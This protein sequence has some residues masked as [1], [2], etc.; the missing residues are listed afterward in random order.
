M[1]PRLA[2]TFACLLAVL[3]SGAGAEG[4]GIRRGEAKAF[5]VLK[6]TKRLPAL[7]QG[8]T[9][10][11]LATVAWQPSIDRADDPE[12]TG[13][14]AKRQLLEASCGA[15]LVV[16]ARVDGSVPFRHPNNRWVLTLH[17]LVVSRVVRRRTPRIAR[18]ERLRYVHPSGELSVAGRI[19]RTT[20]D[21]FPPIVSDEDA[22]FF[23]VQIDATTYRSSEVVPPMAFRG[24]ML[25]ALGEAKPGA[26]RE[27]AAG[28]G[29]REAAR[30]AADAICRPAAIDR[31]WHRRG[32]DDGRGQPSPP[33]FYPP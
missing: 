16:I 4:P 8:D 32:A 14:S 11:T 9:E 10:R 5:D 13:R 20:V 29:A 7:E 15:D 22:L 12:Y 25:D 18:P 17:D 21:R 33:G 30:L 28:F 6:A 26:A 23:L 24:G 19:V 31:T 3:V 1:T 27:P 2:G